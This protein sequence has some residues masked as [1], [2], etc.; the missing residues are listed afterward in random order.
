MTQVQGELEVE[1]QRSASLTYSI[2]IS[3]DADF[4]TV[5]YWPWFD[6]LALTS[7]V[8]RGH[9]IEEASRHAVNLIAEITGQSPEVLEAK[10]DRTNGGT[11][12]V[13]FRQPEATTPKTA[14]AEQI[15]NGLQ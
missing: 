8:P 14:N 1:Y 11:I 9:L 2:T 7:G 6:A 4:A 15:W 12:I 10:W 5:Q 3:E 13:S